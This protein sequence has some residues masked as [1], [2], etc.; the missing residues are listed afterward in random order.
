M[1]EAAQIEES[2]SNLF[3]QRMWESL[4]H[5]YECLGNKGKPTLTNELEFTVLAAIIV[6]CQNPGS[7]SESLKIVSMATGTKCVGADEI[8]EEGKVIHDSHAEVLARRG[9]V[10]YLALWI[11]RV[12][13]DVGVLIDED[14]PLILGESQSTFKVKPS[15]SFY[16]AI[17][18]S[19]CGD[20]SIYHDITGEAAFT[21]AKLVSNAGLQVEISSSCGCV[22]EPSTQQLGSLRLKTGRSDII[23]RSQSKSCS[24][25]IC[26]WMALGLQGGLL[27]AILGHVPLAGVIVAQDPATSTADQLAAL[28][29]AL[30]TRW[31]SSL[32][33][34]R[35]LELYVVQSEAFASSKSIV[36]HRLSQRPISSSALPHP[37]AV[38]DESMLSAKFKKRR[39][40]DDSGSDMKPF[41]CATSINWQLG[42]SEAE[43]TIAQSGLP[44]GASMRQ[45]KHV[46]GGRLS[47][48]WMMPLWTK[49]K[50][51]LI[52]EDEDSNYS[53][54]KKR[55]MESDVEYQAKRQRFFE[56]DT[57]IEWHNHS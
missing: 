56:Q 51:T 10:R 12:R 13:T 53:S 48:C 24:D 3:A 26:R 2:E 39:R 19:P 40:R 36:K 4:V 45:L 52:E 11:D 55:W 18:D 33:G 7:T 54:R 42:Y 47:R 49:I 31:N 21:G 8:D 44:Q 46:K 25:K 37:V 29:R 16:L 22:R 20:A 38:I 6:R 1:M 50:A 17:S 30:I 9:F 43:V 28:Q 34:E 14:C 27:H 32:A 35:Q 15:W 41:P 23:H 5:H 57:F